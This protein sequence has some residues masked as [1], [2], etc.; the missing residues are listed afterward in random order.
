MSAHE[1]LEQGKSAFQHGVIGFSKWDGAALS[2]GW[3]G[4]GIG[5]RHMGAEGANKLSRSGV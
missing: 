3:F 2:L 4:K 5:S 1:A